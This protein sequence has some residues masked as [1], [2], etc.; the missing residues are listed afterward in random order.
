M[1]TNTMHAHRTWKV[2]LKTMEAVLLTGAWQI[3]LH[4]GVG[5][6]LPLHYQNTSSVFKIHNC[7]YLLFT[8]RTDLTFHL[9]DLAALPLWT[10]VTTCCSTQ[11]LPMSYT[12]IS[13]RYMDAIPSLQDHQRSV[14]SGY[15]NFSRVNF[16]VLGEHNRISTHLCVQCA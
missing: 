5:T 14:L 9:P 13:S 2:L 4:G 8:R 3:A 6:T 16:W 1:T 11:A 15:V 12:I 10:R 7:A